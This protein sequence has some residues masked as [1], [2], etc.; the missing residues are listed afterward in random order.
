[1]SISER[2]AIFDVPLSTQR[3]QWVKNKLLELCDVNS[4]TDFGCGNGRIVYWLKAVPHLTAINFVD[5]DEVLLDLETDIHMRP[6][7]HEMLFGRHHSTQPLTIKIFH[8]DVAIPDARLAADCFIMVEV[9]EHMEKD[10][11]DRAVRTIFGHYQPKHVLVTT[12][13]FEF[14][15]LLNRKP[16]DANKFR[17]YD[18]KFEWTRAQFVDWSTDICTRFSYSVQYYGVGSLPGSEP[19]GPCTQIAAFS[20]N[21]AQI[22]SNLEKDLVCFDAMLDKLNVRENVSEWKIDPKQ[23]KISQLWEF[24]ISGGDPKS[25]EEPTSFDWNLE[26]EPIETN[27]KMD[28]D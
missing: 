12:P 13:N 17:H 27:D 4:V 1:M 5:I 3:Y 28:Q 21:N 8:G 26:N 16:E 10:N 11:L 23:N 6:G 2:K 9:I 25:F 15:V 22:Q 20:R 19:Y 14:N 18:H 7:C 24:K